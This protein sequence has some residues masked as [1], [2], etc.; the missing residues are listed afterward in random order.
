ML[1]TMKFLKLLKQ[2][3]TIFSQA[4]IENKYKIMN[5]RLIHRIPDTLVNINT[6]KD[7][8]L[9]D[10]IKY[11]IHN[12]MCYAE[13]KWIEDTKK[14]YPYY[15]ED[16]V[17][18]RVKGIINI[19]ESCER[20][21][22]VNFP[23]KLD[24]GSFK[25]FKGI[26]AE[27][28]QHKLPVAG[29]TRFWPT[30]DESG[31]KGLAALM[32]VQLAENELES[33]VRRYALELSKRKFLSPS[34]DITSGDVHFGPRECSWMLDTY[35]KTLGYKNI[36]AQAAIYGKPISRGGLRRGDHAA[37]YGVFLAVDNFI[38][39]KPWMDEI[40]LQTGWTDKTVILH[41]LI[42]YKDNKGSI[43]G[44]PKAE[45]Y[46]GGEKCLSYEKC[47]IFVPTTLQK[48]ITSEHAKHIKAKIVVEAVNGCTTP[49]AHDIFLKK[50]V[51]VIPDLF[52]NAGSAVAIY[53]EWLKNIRHVSYGR[54][55]G[56]Y[57]K[58]TTYHLL[59]T[60]E[61]S[62][63]KHISDV[64]ISPTKEFF[65]RLTNDPEEELFKSELEYT[66]ELTCLNIM[67]TAQQYGL[68]LDLR[69]AAYIYALDKIF[70]TYE[71]TGLVL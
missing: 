62:V 51:L 7:P 33:I 65:E 6:E 5:L 54:F 32:T 26:R 2:N 61:Q 68:N 18:K 43:T 46:T 16:L 11:Y 42:T 49:A 60:V 31:V 9:N 64:K 19:M 69:T 56:K 30:E 36:N 39:E 37:G 8:S 28:S 22:E 59:D 24:N 57:H 15:N 70:G 25:L 3:P 17:K 44:Y 27:Y 58:E 21:M 55:T 50:N 35:L 14:S 45:Q 38:N 20:Y 52:A 10:M 53:H 66:F 48:S 71:D 41:D 63:K 47:N 4:V 34:V 23:V 1:N 12:A 40:G 13:P 67:L 29:G